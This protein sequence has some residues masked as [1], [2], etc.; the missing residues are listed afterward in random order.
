MTIQDVNPQ[1]L[2]M[3][4]VFSKLLDESG[5]SNNG[6]PQFKAGG[7][8]VGPYLHGPGGLFGVLGLDQPI[9]STHL[10]IGSSLAAALPVQMSSYTNPLFPYITG[11]VR[12]DTQEKDGVC[13]DPEE[14]GNMKTC[15]LTTQ[16]G[17]KEFKTR[18]A[19]VNRI[20]QRR[21]RGEF[22][23]LRIVNS[24]LVQQM[25]G[26]LTQRFALQTPNPIMAGQ[27]MVARIVEVGVAFQRW[28]CPQV[29]TGNPSNS[30]AGGGYKEF[31]GLD[32]TI[33][34]GKVDALSGATCDSLDSLVSDYNYNDVQDTTAPYNIVHVLT[35]MF[36]FLRKKAE[37]QDML[38][39]DWRIVMRSG[40]FDHIVDVW[41]CEYNTYRCQYSAQSGNANAGVSLN[42][43]FAVRM[44]D[45]MRNGKYLLIDG[46]RVPVITDDCITEETAADNASI[47]N[48]AYSSDIYI[49]PLTVRGGQFNS[50]YWEF[51]D[52]RED[53]MPAIGDANA[54]VWFWSDS[55]RFL[56]QIKP[57]YNWCIDLI[58]KMEPRLINRTPQL[59]ARLTN[60]TYTPLIH[61][62]EPLPSQS[63]W[64]DGGNPTGYPAPSP[65]SE[66]NSDGPGGQ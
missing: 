47:A 55:G 19:E 43:D 22:D 50:T 9:I 40:L 2:A 44:R 51:Y 10:N 45:E 28:L 23:D 26:I 39:V 42:D 46:A 25:A 31:P 36:R 4:Q 54:S 5:A 62:P 12:S 61:Y 53:V 3:A 65:Y 63:Y 32:L 17:R 48:G 49:V 58:S 11:F 20:G 18:E 13:D 16:F 57:P 33:S 52:Y 29:F 27:E 66:W 30:S 24:P 6:Q 14:A 64:V 7:N 21:N 41:P 15:I 59:A 35:S 1:A 56:W 34:T 60:V 38:P 8:P 37:M